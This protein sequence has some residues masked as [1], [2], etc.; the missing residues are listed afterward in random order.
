MVGRGSR[1]RGARGQMRARAA[2]LVAA[3]CAQTAVGLLDWAEMVERGL[4]SPTPRSFCPDNASKTQAELLAE[5][6]F[7]DGLEDEVPQ[8]PPQDR[9]IL[10]PHPLVKSYYRPRPPQQR[11][12]VSGNSD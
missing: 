12:P 1:E 8:K 7:P 9:R 5:L 4:F 2:A 6:E 11:P 10:V 3:A